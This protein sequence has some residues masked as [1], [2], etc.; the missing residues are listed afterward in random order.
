MFD[1]MNVQDVFFIIQSEQHAVISAACRAQTE[2]FIRE[3]LA[4]P[5]RVIGQNPG[6]EFD[7]RGGSLLWQLSKSLQGGTGDFDFPRA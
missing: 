1:A 4:E 3:G 5:V 2:K 6:N 7:D